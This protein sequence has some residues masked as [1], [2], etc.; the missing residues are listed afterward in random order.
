MR[1]LTTLTCLGSCL[2]MAALA[3]CGAS[4]PPPQQGAPP[5]E[6][7]IVAPFEMR[8]GSQAVWRVNV[9]GYNGPFTIH[10]DFGG[11]AVVNEH[12]FSN[13][14][15]P[16]LLQ[17]GMVN[18][19]E[20]VKEYTVT[21]SV[22]DKVGETD[23]ST[24]R[25][26]VDPPGDEP[27]PVDPPVKPPVDPTPGN[28]A[29]VIDSFSVSNGLLQV[30]CSDKDGDDITVSVVDEFGNEYPAQSGTETEFEIDQ[31]VGFWQ[32]QVGLE[33]TASDGQDDTSTTATYAP[34]PISIADDTLYA[35]AM[36]GTAPSVRDPQQ[37]S[38]GQSVRVVVF[39]GPT[40]QPFQRMA[41]VAVTCEDGSDYVLGSFDAGAPDSSS[42]ANGLTGIDGIWQL[43]EA[44][45]L[46]YSA[47][48]QIGGIH[49]R[50][51]PGSRGA[52]DF[53]IIPQGALEINGAYGVLFSFEIAFSEP[54]EYRIGFQPVDTISRTYYQDDSDLNEFFW[55]DVT[56]ST[57][58]NIIT[59]N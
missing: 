35:V 43:L 52:L 39:T 45:D 47:D 44:D 37:A 16:N 6:A 25:Y 26:R 58:P 59:V 13:E 20:A 48:D 50:D 1:I 5:V 42:D 23:T 31:W 46:Q 55:G 41:S 9:N 33:I 56:N 40:K 15:S 34:K 21:V 53:S 57:V 30:S 10:W 3:S 28:R 29:P 22:T 7:I 8:G 49:R 12:D 54:G 51:L 4:S 24:F 14:L 32:S 27:D 18:G 11:G 19:T 2:L 38:D 17:V 36:S